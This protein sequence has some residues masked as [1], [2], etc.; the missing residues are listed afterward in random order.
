MSEFEGQKTRRIGAG[1]LDTGVAEV[2]TPEYVEWLESRVR[3]LMG[4][5]AQLR[6]DVNALRV[7]EGRRYR[8][9]GDYLPYGDDEYDR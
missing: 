9:A 5:C 6:K 3:A 2:P 1:D 7:A 4:S 8:S